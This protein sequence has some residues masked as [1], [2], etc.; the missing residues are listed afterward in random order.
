MTLGNRKLP[1]TDKTVHFAGGFVPEKSRCFVISQGQ[2]PVRTG[3]VKICLI[4]ER[5]GHGTERKHLV[6]LFLV[7]E[8]KHPLFIMFPVT[9]DFIKVA[10]CHKGSFCKEPSPFLLLILN[11]S[12]E[13]L[14]NSCAVGEH[15][16]KSLSDNL[17]GGEN[18]EFTSQFIVVAFLRFFDSCKVFFKFCVPGESGSV[19][20]LEHF[21]VLVAPPVRT[22]TG[23]KFK[24]F[25]SAG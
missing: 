7:T 5:T 17:A 8:Y 12:L 16:G 14:N 3:S 20:T 10:L 6:I 24:G 2:I 4:L 1:Y 15:Y 22:R 18:F 11:K 13:K 19:D 23:S 21:V 9:A 25:H